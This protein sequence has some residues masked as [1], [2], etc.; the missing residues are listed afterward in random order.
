MSRRLHARVHGLIQGVGFRPFIYR[1]AASRGLSGFVR[2][3]SGGVEIEAEGATEILDDFLAAIRRRPPSVAR[4]ENVEVEEIPPVGGVGFSVEDSMSTRETAALVSPDLAVCPACR[5]EMRDPGGRRYRYPFTNCTNCGPRF[6]IVEGVPYDRARTTMRVFDLCPECSRERGDAADRRY[7]AEPNACPECGPRLRLLDAAGRFLAEGELALQKAREALASGGI[8]SLKGLGGFHLACDA[9]DG[10]AVRRLRSRKGRPDRPLAVMCRD[11]GVVRAYCEL[12]AAEAAELESPRAPVLLLR[13]RAAAAPGFAAVAEAVAPGHLDLGVMLPYTP[14]HHL[15]LEAGSAACLVMTSG[16]ASEEPIATDNDEAVRKL[17]GMAELLL[18]HDRPIHNRCDDSVGYF[19]GPRLVLIRRSR[20]FA[21]SPLRLPVRV[22]PMLAV[23]AMMSNTFALAEGRRC[24]LS[25]HIGDVDDEDALS[26]QRESMRNLSRWLGLVPEVVA[27]D[28]HPDL[29]TTRLA[30]EL[31]R[32]LRRVGVQHHH[33]HLASA[34]TAAGIEGEVTGLVLDG[35]GW[36]PDRTIWGG[37]ILT[38]RP[39]RFGRAGCLRP[40]PL[41]GGDAAVRRPVRM[42]VAALHVLV[43]GSAELKLDLW[44][45]AGREET[46]VVRAMVD[47]GFNT[48]L[49]SSAGRLF[50]AVSSILG[51]CDVISYEGQAAVALE[52]A[53]GRSREKTG[54]GPAFGISEAGGLIALDPAPVLAG[55]LAGMVGGAEA[56]D[57]AMAFHAALS[58]ALVAACRRIRAGGGPDR[59]V[60]C[61]GV[62][63]NRILTRLTS[64]ALRRAGLTPV[65]PGEVPV[66]DAGLALGQVVS[67]GSLPGGW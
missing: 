66:N 44:R 2:N 20:G 33:A 40:L 7:H 31:G 54:G 22:P 63:Q 16:N 65:C 45:R 34:M 13:K 29:P 8:V 57:L 56:P 64:A 51:I 1:E 26:F 37:E 30:T 47:R 62:F 5:W 67:A 43:P 35:T 42:A 60:L 19:A 27:H 28:L 48:P 36:G 61:G 17:G 24:F 9:T 58:D 11:A 12:S 55:L 3:T 21:P 59:V 15:L 38:G 32:N 23:G 4:V 46:D 41:P 25:Q 10:A 53:A 52:Q 14:L 50:D 18:V 6:T 39:G 49:T